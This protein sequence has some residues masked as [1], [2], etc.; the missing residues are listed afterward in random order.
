M[1]HES[2]GHYGIR[3]VLGPEFETELERIGKLIPAADLEKAIDTYG[4]DLAVEEYLATEASTRN[5]TLWQQLSRLSEQPCNGW[6]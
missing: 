5:P 1:L 4:K 3:Q 6:E 2:V